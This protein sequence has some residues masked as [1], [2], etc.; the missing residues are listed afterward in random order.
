MWMEWT[1]KTIRVE[2]FREKFSRIFSKL[3]IS[4]KQKTG[5]EKKTGN[6]IAL[7]IPRRE[8]SHQHFYFFIFYLMNYVVSIYRI[9]NI[10]YLIV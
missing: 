8:E 9:V 10:T 5:Q 6:I 7:Y 4:K 3:S 2:K 1:I